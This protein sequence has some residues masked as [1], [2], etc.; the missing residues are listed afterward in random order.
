MKHLLAALFAAFCITTNAQYCAYGYDSEYFQRFLGANTVYVQ[1]TGNAEFDADMENALSKYWTVT[2]YRMVDEKEMA[3]KY[4]SAKSALLVPLQLTVSGSVNYKYGIFA[5]IMGGNESLSTSD[6]IAFAHHDYK[7]ITTGSK[8]I[9]KGE[10][11]TLAG[12]WL[13]I[14]DIIKGM[15]DAIKYVKE[16][17]C[18]FR[19]GIMPSIEYFNKNVYNKKANRL[20]NK[21]LCVYAANVA[22]A[23]KISKIYP[24]KLKFVDKEELMEVIEGKKPDAVYM[25]LTGTYSVDALIITDPIKHE[26]ICGLPFGFVTTV[27]AGDFKDIMKQIEKADKQ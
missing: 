12:L 26:V 7:E 27:D 9:S 20:K 25:V 18:E 23:E 19:S 14:D 22:N 17:K 24:Y 11:T 13:R 1:K 8:A 10:S 2:Q 5:L 4:K 6:I 3:P 21:T 16:T 15:N